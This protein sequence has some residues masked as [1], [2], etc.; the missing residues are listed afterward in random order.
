MMIP[1]GGVFCAALRRRCT[2]FI[3]GYKFLPRR[4]IAALMKSHPFRA[5]DRHKGGSDTS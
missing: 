5:D 4:L 2:K 3:R 1:T